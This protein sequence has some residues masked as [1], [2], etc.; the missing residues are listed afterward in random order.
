MKEN[1]CLLCYALG[2]GRKNTN[3]LIEVNFSHPA[4]LHF[5]NFLCSKGC[6]FIRKR[7]G[8][9]LHNFGFYKAEKI[10]WKKTLKIV[11]INQNFCIS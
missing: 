9:M 8:K 4:T 10:P 3:R 1:D 7:R 11:E 2:G 6:W 5:L